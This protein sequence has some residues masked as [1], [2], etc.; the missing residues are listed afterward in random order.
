MASPS[1]DN[2]ESSL[3]FKSERLKT[4]FEPKVDGT[5]GFVKFWSAAADITPEELA[6][7]G[8]YFLKKDD[9]CACIFCRRI[10]GAWEGDTVRGE[11]QRHFP[12]CPFIRE[13]S[14]TSSPWSMVMKKKMSFSGFYL[15]YLSDQVR[16]FKCGL[17]LRNWSDSMDPLEMHA[18][19]S[20]DC[21]VVKL[22][23]GPLTSKTHHD[24]KKMVDDTLVDQVIEQGD[25]ERHVIAMGF[26]FDDVK[27]A[28][29]K[30]LLGQSNSTELQ[31]VQKLFA[32]AWNRGRGSSRSSGKP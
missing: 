17:G 24:R 19:Y 28:V 12:R 1:L 8:F 14:F 7:D 5:C 27:A 25:I 26:P 32:S 4:F 11:H 16:C 23:N 10:I 6:K 22:L 20:P 31:N 18:E 21:T 15:T 30:R 9:H 13:A 3:V 2:T 29:K